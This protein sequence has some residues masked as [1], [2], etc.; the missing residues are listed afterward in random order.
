MSQHDDMTCLLQMRDHARE[1]VAY[2]AGKTREDMERDRIL[3]LALVRLIEVVGEAAGRVSDSGRKKHDSLPWRGM[4]GMRNRLIHG[5]D[6]INTEVLWN[7]IQ[8]DLP[9]LIRKI[10]RLLPPDTDA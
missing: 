9:E 6:A 1:A 7:T 10:D 2:C 5:Y 4:I 8:T 3:Q